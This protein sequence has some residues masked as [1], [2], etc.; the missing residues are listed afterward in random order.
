M[1][2]SGPVHLASFFGGKNMTLEHPPHTDTHFKADKYRTL[3]FGA[4]KEARLL[5]LCRYS[6]ENVPVQYGNPRDQHGKVNQIPSKHL[7][8]LRTISNP[9]FRFRKCT[10]RGRNTSLRFRDSVNRKP[11]LHSL[12]RNPIESPGGFPNAWAQCRSYCLNRYHFWP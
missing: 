4:E 3:A 1:R 5:H 7:L 8:S 9:V 12:V 10:N 6:L 2:S 11:G